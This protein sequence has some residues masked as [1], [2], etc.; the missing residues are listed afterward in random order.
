MNTSKPIVDTL[1]TGASGPAAINPTKVAQTLLFM[2]EPTQVI[3]R[4][5][6][7]S[8]A[9]VSARKVTS[10]NIISDIL[11]STSK[12]KAPKKFRS[13]YPSLT[14]GIKKL[15][16]RTSGKPSKGIGFLI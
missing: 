11:K 9:K 5:A 2:K 7:G 15:D 4:F 13:S 3:D 1:N 16:Y 8:V 12:F 6:V 14:Q 10:T